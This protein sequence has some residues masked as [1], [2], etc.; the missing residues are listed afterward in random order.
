MT[1]PTPTTHPPHPPHLREIAFV[2]VTPE[3]SK[4]LR[5][6]RPAIDVVSLEPGR[7]GL[8]RMAE[9]LSGRRR[10]ETIHIIAQGTPGTLHLAGDRIDVPALVMRIGVLA[11]IRQALADDAHILIYGAPVLDGPDGRLF[12]DYLGAATGTTVAASIWFARNFF[13]ANG[14]WRL[15]TADGKPVDRPPFNL[16]LAANT[17]APLRLPPTGRPP[18][19]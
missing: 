12:G 15:R 5:S 7:R 3:S 17:A 13:G 10:M 19:R 9:A 11:Q 1:P 16:R 2:D 6:L 14:G 4:R 18:P 8:E